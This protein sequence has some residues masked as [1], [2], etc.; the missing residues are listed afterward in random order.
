M[1]P[2]TRHDDEIK[3][4][5]NGRKSSK[6]NDKSHLKEESKKKSHSKEKSKMMIIIAAIMA[7]MSLFHMRLPGTRM[8]SS[9]PRGELPHTRSTDASLVEQCSTP[10]QRNRHN[11]DYCTDYW[12][13]LRAAMPCAQLGVDIDANKGYTAASWMSLWNPE[14]GI[15]PETWWKA[16]GTLDLGHGKVRIVGGATEGAQ[17]ACG[18]CND[19]KEGMLEKNLESHLTRVIGADALEIATEGTDLST[20]CARNKLN[21]VSFQH[22]HQ[23]HQPITIT[24]IPKLVPPSP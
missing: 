16:E 21:I 9:H 23:Q 6:S 1:D 14:V 19:C 2:S 22:Q 4:R 15:S 20:T 18:N 11:L 7:S 5:M 24:A 17:F 13:L 3:N 10:E 12:A 8:I